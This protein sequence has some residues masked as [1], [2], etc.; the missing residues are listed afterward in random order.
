MKNSHALSSYA[1]DTHSYAQI[2]F[3]LGKPPTATPLGSEQ[4]PTMN[5]VAWS[6]GCQSTGAFGSSMVWVPCESHAYY[7]YCSSLHLNEE[8]LLSPGSASG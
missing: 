5:T 8:T 6:C 2:M 3:V 1:Q 4:E 7:R